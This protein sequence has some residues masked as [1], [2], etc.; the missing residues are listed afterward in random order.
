MTPNAGN[1]NKRISIVK[2][3]IAQ[4]E[5]G[6][7]VTTDTTVCTVWAGVQDATMTEYYE[8]ARNQMDHVV[9]F[10]IRYR[11]DIAEGMFVVF[12]GGKHEIKEIN[13]GLYQRAYL[14]LKTT[15]WAVSA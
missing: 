9:N 6:N 1:L 15:R 5:E 10:N 7:R 4:D 13:K 8:A 14:T 11:K 2:T 12:D 3:S